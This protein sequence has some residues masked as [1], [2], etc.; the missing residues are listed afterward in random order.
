MTDYEPGALSNYT[1]PILIVPEGFDI[2][3]HLACG[4]T[5][6]LLRSSI[7]T[8]DIVRSSDVLHADGS[9][10]HQGSP[11]MRCDSCKSTVRGPSDYSRERGEE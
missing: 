7:Q 3:R 1:K 5:A 6:F 11:A 9:P 8:G 2:I 10:M 4:Q